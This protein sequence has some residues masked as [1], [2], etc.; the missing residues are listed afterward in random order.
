[1]K[2]K[3]SNVFPKALILLFYELFRKCR[4]KT[5]SPGDSEILGKKFKATMPSSRKN[6]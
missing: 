3:F 4:D 6:N 5:F 2:L 1:M